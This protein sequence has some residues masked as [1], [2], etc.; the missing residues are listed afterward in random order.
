M[1][2]GDKIFQL[3]QG[4]I[5]NEQ[6]RQRLDLER[7]QFDFNL[8]Q[9][10]QTLT[11]RQQELSARQGFLD[12]QRQQIEL[13]VEKAKDPT[14]K[15]KAEAELAL[16]IAQTKHENALTDKTLGKV[17]EE[18]SVI[19]QLRTAPLKAQLDEDARTA[20]T[21]TALRLI[22]GD[23]DASSFIPANSQVNFDIL[24]SGLAAAGVSTFKEL[25]AARDAAEKDVRSILASPLAGTDF[26]A[27]SQ[28]QIENKAKSIQSAINEARKIFDPPPSRDEFLNVAEGRVDRSL[29]TNMFEKAV[30]A[31][32]LRLS[33]W[34]AP[35]NTTIYNNAISL[36][37]LGNSS[38]FRNFVRQ[39]PAAL[40]NEQG[41]LTGDGAVN[42]GELMLAEGVEPE[43]VRNFVAEFNRQ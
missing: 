5:A 17:G 30:P 34:K 20:R 36:L 35:I 40:L 2:I 43:K 29:A 38:P 37:R 7:K 42:L 14:A 13:Q 11:L 4:I 39:N 21:D 26:I 27:K 12:I 1:A 32:T 22:V 31:G 3:A 10:E 6:N 24:N 23:K 9:S 8:K 41:R 19:D 18:V 25:L 15:A 33:I 16:T 28:T